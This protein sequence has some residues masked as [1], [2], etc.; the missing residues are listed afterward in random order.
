MRLQLPLIPPGLRQICCADCGNRKCR[1]CGRLCRGRYV[2]PATSQ[3][4]Y[5]EDCY[6]CSSCGG[7][8]GTRLG[9][10]SGVVGGSEVERAGL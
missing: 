7:G 5:H 1:K 10:D 9:G 6:T 3:G 8:L 4:V 2:A